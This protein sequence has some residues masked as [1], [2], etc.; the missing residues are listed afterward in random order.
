MSHLTGTHAAQNYLYSL[1]VLNQVTAKAETD[2]GTQANIVCFVIFRMYAGSTSIIQAE[3][4]ETAK[5][6]HIAG[7]CC[8]SVHNLCKSI[9]C[10]C[11]LFP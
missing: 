3:Q 1:A 5:V 7:M 2:G 9:R 10:A 8:V 6:R 11:S 4:P